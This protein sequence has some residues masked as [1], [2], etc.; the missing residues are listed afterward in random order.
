MNLD[1][2]LRSRFSFFFAISLVR[3][4]LL[5]GAIAT[6]VAISLL[7]LG[8]WHPFESLIYK[9]F[10][11]LYTLSPWSDRPIVSGAIDPNWL[12]IALL[13]MGIGFSLWLPSRQRD[14]QFIL[15]L[16]T[17][18]GWSLL[19]LVIFWGGYWL[20]TAAPLG[21]LTLTTVIVMLGDQYRTMQQLQQSEERYTLAIQ[22]SNQGLWDWHFANDTLYV[23]PR[24]LAMLGCEI[25]PDHT[26]NPT[27]PGR[28]P[29][30]PLPPSYISLSS[31]D[32]FSRVHPDDIQ[33]LKDSI[34]AHLEGKTERF[35]REYRMR[36]DDGTY[37]WVLTQALAV[38]NRAGEADRMAGCQ[39]D[40]T[41][42]KEA[43]DKLHRNAF[44][45]GLTGLPNRA[46][47]IERLRE[48]I[49][50]T[51]QF[52]SVTFAVLWL[53]LDH[54]KVVNN[55]LGGDIGDRLLISAA[56]RLRSFLP[57]ENVIARISGDEFVILLN[58]INSLADATR[59][60]DRVQQ[61]LALPFNLNEHQ[62]FTT[63]SIGIA[64]S[65]SLYQRPEHMM[66]DADTAMHRAKASG[67]ARYQ[68]FDTAM[69]QR[70][71][72]RLQLE[73]DLRRAIAATHNPE[74]DRQELVL[75]YQPIVQLTTRK[76]IGFEALLR[77][78]H[79]E[80][81]L[82]SPA[83][84]I[85]MAEETGLIVQLGWWVLREACHQM[86]HWHMQL[87]HQPPLTMNVNLSSRQFA[88]SGLTEQTRQILEETQLNPSSLKL[89]L[90][91]SMV[92]ENASSVVAVLRQIRALGIQ[93]AID[94]FGTGYSSLSYLPRFPINT[95]KIDR[96][97]ISKMGSNNDGLEIVR[98]IL[99]LA[100]NLGMDVT[101]EGVESVEQVSQLLSMNCDYGQGYLFAKPL[102]RES[103]THLLTQ[104]LLD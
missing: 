83:R 44:Y 102:D 12:P 81:G 98:T 86:R 77:W 95:L 58:Q 22:A 89:E 78:Q 25:Q 34:S 39:T 32:W 60:A 53:D 18:T 1:Q 10:Y 43:D 99:T 45:D 11:H 94:D 92:M 15:W 101:A 14:R 80:H 93:L 65:S 75:Y 28:S 61:L 71:L 50:V 48:A 35:E 87:P 16:I 33:S 69:H 54:F 19:S 21:L 37:R 96:S 26:S 23:S 76:I 42:R 13:G 100:H 30:E 38:R 40:I 104:Q 59:T 91:E 17:T 73:N 8:V 74:G 2:G 90:T 20:P 3:E 79:P 66:R 9:A 67:R 5:S 70:L 51:Q 85:P 36:H 64:M 63:V 103:A 6:L 55:S 88:M 82:I 72:E 31:Q 27:N 4:Q 97:F 84:F 46:L 47:F 24:W 52:P 7:I 62:V 41:V 49:A 57:V 29:L 56:Q 68:V